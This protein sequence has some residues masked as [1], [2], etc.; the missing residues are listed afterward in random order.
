MK[1]RVIAAIL[2]LTVSI[3]FVSCEDDDNLL[4][5]TTETKLVDPKK[6]KPPTSG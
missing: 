3:G 5:E 4:D 1:K 2:L 6:V